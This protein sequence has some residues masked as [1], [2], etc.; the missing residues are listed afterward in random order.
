MLD[1]IKL[2]KVEKDGVLMDIN[3]QDP[4]RLVTDGNEISVVGN[5]FKQ[6]VEKIYGIID[7]LKRSW[8]GQSAQRF[9][10]GVEGYRTD[11]ETFAKAIGQF[12]EL[13]SAVGQDYQN[14][15]NEL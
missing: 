7:D 2:D 4:G 12:G 9:T 3:I 14:L 5:Q 11:F 13:I 6:E 1:T 10:E 8:A 15:E